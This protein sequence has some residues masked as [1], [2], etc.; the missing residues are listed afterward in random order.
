MRVGLNAKVLMAT[1]FFAALT[2]LSYFWGG[3]AANCTCLVLCMAFS[4][5]IN[6]DVI[7][8]LFR[9][10]KGGHKDA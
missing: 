6:R 10:L 7:A 1:A 4:A 5:V 8:S 2:T 9:K 3:I